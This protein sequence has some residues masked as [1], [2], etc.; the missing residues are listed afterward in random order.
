[1]RTPKA[2]L[3]LG[4]SVA[5]LG[6]SRADAVDGDAALSYVTLVD[7]GE[8]GTYGAGASLSVATRISGP[9]GVVAEASLSGRSEDFR[10]SNGSLYDMRYDSIRGGLRLGRW[11]GR[12]RPYGQVAAGPIRRR[13]RERVDA[14]GREGAGWSSATD[15]SIAPGLGLDV[16]VTDSLAIRGAADLAF[17]SR[18]D[19]NGRGYEQK[20]SSFRAGLAFRWGR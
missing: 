2:A 20:V 16:S 11:R 4:L 5:A 18:E 14:T 7:H 3:I 12:V 17:L 13:F 15:F 10:S 1:M 8:G 19:R 6:G 9:L